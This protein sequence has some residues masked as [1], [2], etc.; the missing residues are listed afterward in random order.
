M[1]GLG[2][3][4]IHLQV[5]S[6]NPLHAGI[7][8]LLEGIEVDGVHIFTGVIDDRQVEMAVGLGV[9]MTGEMLGD[10]HHS[11]AL[12]PFHI[13]YA[14]LGYTLGVGT[15]RARP[16]NRVV[17]IA[18]DI[19]HWGKI[20]MDSHVLALQAYL[21]SHIVQQGVHLMWQQ[22]KFGVLWEGVT[23]FQPHSQSPF[24]IDAYQQRH[25][26]NILEPLD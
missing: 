20:D 9:A 24:G 12:Q 21:P 5:G 15:K 23:I 13:L 2:L 6:H 14:Q 25:L 4:G 17:G 22:A 10:S 1:V 3:I 11:R 26:A 19:N 18:V 8:Q 16:Y 7:N